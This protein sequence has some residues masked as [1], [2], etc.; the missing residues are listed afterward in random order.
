MSDIDACKKHADNF[1]IEMKARSTSNSLNTSQFSDRRSSG[2][3]H[4]HF[5]PEKS[6]KFREEQEEIE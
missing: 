3:K 6:V 5:A 1:I 2:G 4:V